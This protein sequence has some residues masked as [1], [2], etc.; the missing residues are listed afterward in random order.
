MDRQ[1]KLIITL[2][3]PDFHNE[4]AENKLVHRV[5][6]RRIFVFKYRNLL[7][8][9]LNSFFF[10]KLRKNIQTSNTE[11][12]SLLNDATYKNHAG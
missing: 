4:G 1:M 5:S 8:Q 9:C 3:L 12:S 10:L 7:H 2:F 6:F 11:L